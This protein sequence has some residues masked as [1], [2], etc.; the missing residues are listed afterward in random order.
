VVTVEDVGD[1]VGGEQ[2]AGVQEV[3]RPDGRVALAHATQARHLQ[4]E[5]ISEGNDT[6]KFQKYKGKHYKNTITLKKCTKI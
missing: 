3:G 6:Y 4:G 1:G 5:W 2:P